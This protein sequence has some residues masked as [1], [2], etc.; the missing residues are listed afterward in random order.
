MEKFITHIGVTLLSL[1][2]VFSSMSFTVQKHYCGEVLVGVSYVGK[3]EVCCASKDAKQ[4]NKQEGSSNKEDCCNDELELIES[5]T[6]EKEK[7]TSLSTDDIEFVV[8]YVFSYIELFQQIDIEKEFY[9]DFSPP[10]IVQDIQLLQ[11][12]FLI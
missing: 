8:Y 3:A 1:I 12:I 4:K 9:K 7:L 6:F 11:K 5:L 2:V 10:D